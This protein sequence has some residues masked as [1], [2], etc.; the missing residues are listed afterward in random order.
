MQHKQRG[1][2]VAIGEAKT[3]NKGTALIQ[4]QF[5]QENG[6]IFYPSALGK[7]TELL[8]GIMPGDVVELE[9]HITGSKGLYNNVIIDNV[10]R[11]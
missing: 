7:K 2:V 4:I 8:A 1:I 5:E 10:E 3:T 6:Q 11:V 9:Y